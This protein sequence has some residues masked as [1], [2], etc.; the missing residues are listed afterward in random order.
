MIL[1][2]SNKL[3]PYEDETM[4]SYMKRLA[5]ANGFDTLSELYRY[6]INQ[7]SQYS[8]SIL[9]FSVT[10]RYNTVFKSLGFEDYA[11]L[12][13]SHTEW[14]FMSIFLS[15]Y[16][17]VSILNTAFCNANKGSTPITISNNYCPECDKKARYQHRSHILPGVKVCHK[18][19]CSLYDKDNRPLLEEVSEEDIAYAE[20]VHKLLTSNLSTNRE[21]IN[22]HFTNNYEKN[23][24]LLMEE[25]PNVKDI[26]IEEPI[27]N[28]ND[29]DCTTLYETNNLGEYIHEPCGTHF[30]MTPYGMNY[31]FDC[32]TCRPEEA[33]EQYARQMDKTGEYKLIKYAP[34]SVTLKHLTCGN[35]YVTRPATFF[36]GARCLCQTQRTPYVLEQ[37]NKQYPDFKFIKYSGKETKE[38]M[39]HISCGN[40]FTVGLDKWL[41]NP[42]CPIC[43]P[44]FSLTKDVVADKI[45]ELGCKLIKFNKDDYKCTIEC[46]E[47]HRFTKKYYHF[48]DNPLCPECTGG[49]DYNKTEKLRAYIKEH[50]SENDLVFIDELPRN[51]N[52]LTDFLSRKYPNE[53]RRI[54]LGIYA[55]GDTEF[56]NE[57]ILK[58][59]FLLRRSEVTGY[60]YGK[61]FAYELGLTDKKP[62]Y[63]SIATKFSTLKDGD[64]RTFNGSRA[65]IKGVVPKFTSD[66]WRVAQ[67]AEFLTG[68]NH[69]TKDVDKAEE[70]IYQYMVDNHI[71]TK[72]VEELLPRTN[73][74]TDGSIAYLYKCEQAQDFKEVKHEKK[75]RKD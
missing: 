74:F 38:T 31:Y 20:Y 13:L 33:E 16:Q 55:R 43:E 7:D 50:Y 32:P 67:I 54:S 52:H 25:Y 22:L 57:E 47:G 71:T 29:T 41:K 28:K 26:P 3:K 48:L 12:Y 35:E 23:V 9:R 11:D 8:A 36:E 10:T 39:Q 46:P 5:I 44:K 51:S 34:H 40:T 59:K 72:E 68:I 65:R 70:V 21:T 69:Y 63:P 73:R 27:I 15:R 60:L 37:L 24:K 56:S 17:Q 30:C 2:K 61:S 4:S 66:N 42:H 49:S 18:H 53:L 19:H 75:K 45:N 58:Q 14:P 62:E 6:V 1:G 64:L